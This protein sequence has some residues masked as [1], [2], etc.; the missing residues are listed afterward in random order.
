[1]H[2]VTGTGVYVR[3]FDFAGH[4]RFVR[5]IK[6]S[7]DQGLVR[8]PGFVDDLFAD[9]SALDPA[10]EVRRRAGWSV[11]RVSGRLK[12]VYKAGNVMGGRHTSGRAELSATVATLAAADEPVVR[13]DC[14][15]VVNGYDDL[16]NRVSPRVQNS[17]LSRVLKYA[18]DR[19]RV[20]NT[21]K[22]KAH[23]HF[24]EVWAMTTTSFV[25]GETTSRTSL[26]RKRP[27]MLAAQRAGTRRC[28]QRR[29]GVSC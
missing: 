24:E 19:G 11:V 4:C 6:R 17:D 10:C 20:L 25:F 26:L 23:Q 2:F 22:V 14:L 16:V 28:R 3:R 5:D 1:M 29:Y 7:V 8:W 27:R 12:C 9:G 21:V 18:A 15:G 13:S